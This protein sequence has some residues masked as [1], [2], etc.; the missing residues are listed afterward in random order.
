MKSGNKNS[1][2][3][4]PSGSMQGSKAKAIVGNKPSGSPKKNHKV[5]KP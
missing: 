5:Q 1:G 3:Q 2:K 4:G